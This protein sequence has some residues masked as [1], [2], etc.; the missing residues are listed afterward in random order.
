MQPNGSCFFDTWIHVFTAP[1]LLRHFLRLLLLD[2]VLLIGNWV[3]IRLWI[4]WKTTQTHQKKNVQAQPFPQDSLN[5]NRV[6]K[7]SIILIF[8]YDR[9]L[10]SSLVCTFIQ[11]I[12]T[13]TFDIKYPQFSSKCNI[14]MVKRGVRCCFFVTENPIP[15]CLQKLWLRR[16][17]LSLLFPLP[18]HCA[19]IMQTLYQI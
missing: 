9:I 19:D 16:L 13:K 12:K 5:Q 18:G 7:L 8:K 4:C 11:T 10:K 2:F 15:Y 1:V 17:L 3:P 6:R 14:W